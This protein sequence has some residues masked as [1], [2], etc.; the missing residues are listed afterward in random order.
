MR[1]TNRWVAAVSV[2]ALLV[3]ACG[4]DGDVDPPVMPEPV[5]EEPAD[6]PAESPVEQPETDEPEATDPVGDPELVWRYAHEEG[7]R[8]LAISPDNETLAAGERA[9]YIHQFADGFLLDAFASRAGPRSVTYSPDGGLLGV[10]MALYGAD[11]FDTET[12]ESAAVVG[13]GFDNIVA[14][15]PDGQYVAA[16][17]RDGTVTIMDGTD[18][19]VLSSLVADEVQAVTAMTF[20][21]TSDLLAVTYFD[22]TVRVWDLAT[23]S[24]AI[25]LEVETGDGSCGLSAAAF[26]F[27]PDGAQ[28][29]GAVRDGGAQLLR[30][31]SRDGT[32]VEAEFEVAPRVRD[33]AFS[34]DGSMLAL[35]A[36]AATQVID[37]DRQE[38]RYLINETAAAGLIPRPTS[39]VF[40]RDGGHV[41]FGWTDGTIEVWRLPGAE[42]LTAPERAVCDPLPLPGDVLFDTGSSALL[43]DADAALTELAEH[44]RDGFAEATLTFVGHTDSRGAASAN[45]QL[46]LARAGA[47]ADWFAAWM[48]DNGID[49]W[50]LAT[51][52]RG[53]TELKVADVDADGQFLAG[54]GAINRRVD[55]EIDAPNCD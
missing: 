47:V 43:A 11:L 44:L 13:D 28:M 5:A 21:P 23:E 40:G 2:A 1:R 49:G 32:T 46:S 30:V 27:T 24:V 16:G 26:T 9:T 52:G 38:V 18:F 41:A 55:I 33:L 51:D 35:A 19:A 22:C 50:E 12:G 14:F 4:E 36:N 48:S 39:A 7:V 17:N 45:Q 20:D 8:R 37:W 29:V 42:V 34:P 15:S 3:A 6:T 10:G 25:D 31:W 53:D 54:A